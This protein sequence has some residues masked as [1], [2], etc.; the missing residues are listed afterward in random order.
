MNDDFSDVTLVS[1]DRKHIKAHRNILTFCS[2]V[3]RY[4]M[5]LDKNSNTIIYLRGVQ[6]S[7]LESVVKFIY[8]GEATMQEDSMNEFLNV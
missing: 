6:F 8:L 4:L 5:N 3:F 1:E 7:Y 2:P